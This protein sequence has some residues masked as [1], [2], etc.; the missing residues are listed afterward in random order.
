MKILTLAALAAAALAVPAAA[1]QNPAPAQRTTG[2]V[3]VSGRLTFYDQTNYNGNDYAVDDA[4]SR[5]SWD[6][7]IRSI[8]IHPGDRWQICARPR[9]AECIV[10]DRSV[11][12]AEM[13]GIPAGNTIG[14]VRRAPAE[15]HN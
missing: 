9:F 3:T 11:A 10:L 14:S 2:P 4:V 8:A 15:A 13:I 12:D 5:F 1:M 6:Q 7:N